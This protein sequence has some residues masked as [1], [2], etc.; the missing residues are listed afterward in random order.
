MKMDDL[1]GVY[2]SVIHLDKFRYA[3]GPA[4]RCQAGLA[5][6][7]EL[8]KNITK[9]DIPSIGYHLGANKLYLTSHR[10]HH[11]I[12]GDFREKRDLES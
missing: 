9:Q 6:C 11:V 12:Q 3:S 10:S 5:G 7:S 2:E 4:D 1:S 8:Q